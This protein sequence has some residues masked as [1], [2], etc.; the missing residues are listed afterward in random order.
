MRRLFNKT[1][2]TRHITYVLLIAPLLIV[3][4]LLA[5]TQASSIELPERSLFIPDQS[6]NAVTSYTVSFMSASTLLIGSIQVQ[7]CANNPFPNT[8]CDAPAGLDFT[9][10]TLTNQ[11]GETGFSI[12]SNSTANAIIFSRT[13]TISGNDQVSIT[14]NNVKNPTAYGSYYVRLQTYPT[15]DASGSDNG[16]GGMSFSINKI[17]NVQ[18]TVP[19]YLLFCAG[20]VI[21]NYDCD[22]ASGNYIDFGD[23]SSTRTASASSMLV[24][25]T[26]A[27]GG[28]NITVNGT[29]PTSG[30]NI[31]TPLNPADVSRPGV[32]QFGINLRANSTPQ[33]GSNTAGP[34]LGA[35]LPDYNTADMFVFKPTDMIAAANAADDYRAY[36]ISYIVNIAQNQP[37]GIYVSTLTFVSLANF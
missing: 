31:I 19:P 1:T 20:L 5:S 25:A 18:A 30:N 34:G 22:S 2:H 17:I 27:A 29:P 10:A 9:G 21:T 14:V 36:T 26:N 12:S 8:P 7:I 33:V 16:H 35:P 37:I 24:A 6:S 28:Y 23:L 15:S 32:S 11:S 3:A 4:G 13:P